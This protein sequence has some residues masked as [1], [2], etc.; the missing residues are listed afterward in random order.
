MHSNDS[1]GPDLFSRQVLV[2]N[3]SLVVTDTLT[4]EKF[5]VSDYNSGYVKVDAIAKY[6]FVSADGRK[7]IVIS[8]LYDS[9]SMDCWGIEIFDR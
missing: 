9:S 3:D 4:L 5:C 6:L 8:R 2:L 7:L 1:C